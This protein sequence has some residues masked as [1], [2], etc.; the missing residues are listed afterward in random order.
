MNRTVN[1]Q[2]RARRSVLTVTLIVLLV[3]LPVVGVFALDWGGSLTTTS[4]IQSLPEDSDDNIFSNTE[5][6]TFYLNTALGTKYRLESQAAAR[7][8]ADPLLFAADIER[9]YLER[10]RR[11]AQGNLNEFVTRAG[12]QT[13]TDPSGMVVRQTVDGVTAI[14][15]YPRIEV[16]LAA[17]YTGLV[18][19]EFTGASMSLR[20]SLDAGDDD[21]YFGP[22]RL[23]GQGRVTMSNLFAGQSVRLAFTFQEDLRDPDD[24]IQAGDDPGQL[25]QDVDPGGLLDTQYIQLLLDGPIPV[26]GMPGQIFYQAGYIL[27]LGRT[28]SLVEDDKSQS[29]ESYQYKPIRAHLARL[30]LQY[31]LPSFLSTAAGLGVTFSSGDDGYSS[32]TE[33]NTGDVST[34][35]TPV[36][37]GAAGTVFGLEYGNTT[38][39]EVFYSMRPLERLHSPFL[40]TM[41]VQVAGYSF[42]RSVGEGPVSAPDVDP[43]TDESYLGTEVDLALRFRPFSDLGFGLSTGVFFANDD[44]MFDG[45]N[46]VDYL[47]RLDASLSF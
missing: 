9:L 15:R 2:N 46:S 43:G 20:D 4:S 5:R 38:V 31:F 7:F 44:A 34:M 21:V 22:A 11:P 42:F 18:N 47:V 1:L 25:D 29:G 10:V 24:V 12:R 41:Q 26:G 27:N 3:V 6:L 39:I 40:N 17:G 36:T 19:K 35:F 16:G 32:F 23:V 33:G 45:T 37:P 28:L 30:Q 14:V 8:D 13:I